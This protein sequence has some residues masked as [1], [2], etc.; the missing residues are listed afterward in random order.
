MSIFQFEARPDKPFYLER[1]FVSLF[2]DRPG[3][4]WRQVLSAGWPGWREWYTERGGSEKSVDQAL[5]A[6]RRY[7]PEI[8][9]M[10]LRLGEQKGDDDLLE[11][12]CFWCPPMY[13]VSCSQFTSCDADGPFL[14][15]NYDLDP[16]LSEAILL[17][18]AWRGKPVLGMVEG[19]VG[20]S[21]GINSDGL[22]AS[23]SFGGR[24]CRGQGFGIPLIIRY[25]LE[26]C[27]DVQDAVQALRSIPAHMA[28]NVTLCDRSGAA[29][30]VMLSPDRPAIVNPEGWATNHQ[31]GVEWE[32]HAKFTRTLERGDIL[33]ELTSGDRPTASQ[34]CEV[35]ASEP[36]YATDYNYG[37]G[38]VFTSLYRPLEMTA[39]L[40]W[41]KGSS[42]KRGL[43]D[44]DPTSVRVVYEDAGATAAVSEGAE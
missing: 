37:Y 12:L 16:S 25:I 42:L 24:I 30:T 6:V 9:S 41:G 34:A 10:L 26:V 38:T 8:E 3:D 35:F 19:L 28:Y 14:I 31:V 18:S 15:R 5:H 36:F 27:S 44:D 43:S 22:A 23:L 32:R 2:D 21:D 17:R 40:L 11:F 1:Q 4:A 39:E 33:S 13:L 20:L 29:A 7:L